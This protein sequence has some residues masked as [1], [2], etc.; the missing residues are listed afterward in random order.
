ML[1]HT[2]ISAKGI[3]ILEPSSPLETADFEA[4]AHDIDPYL[5]E[6]GSLSGV[7]IVAKAFPGWMN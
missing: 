6:H 7:L 1:K 2:L 3:L 5:A 4:V